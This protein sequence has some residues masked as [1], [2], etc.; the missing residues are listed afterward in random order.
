MRKL[1]LISAVLLASVSA[2]AEEGRGAVVAST[3][4]AATSDI[5]RPLPPIKKSETSE[6]PKRQSAMPARPLP[7]TSARALQA[8]RYASREARARQIAA[9]Y[10]IHW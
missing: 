1:L 7:P 5:P 9:R 2:H 8:Q 10:G 3:D 6:T 4:P